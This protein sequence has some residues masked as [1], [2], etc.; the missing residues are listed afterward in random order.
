[1]KPPKPKICEHCKSKF[2]P[3][4][5]FQTWCSNECAYEIA[6]RKKEKQIKKEIRV[7]KEKIKTHSDHLK[8][9]Q[10]LV[11]KYVRLRDYG[12]PCI[13]CDAILGRVKYDAG[14]YF[15]VGGYPGLRFDEEN[16]HGQC[17]YCNQHLHSNS[18]EYEERLPARIGQGQFELLKSR[19]HQ[20]NKLTISEIEEMKKLYKE[21]LKQIQK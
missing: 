5:S 8:D 6:K 10:V 13:S 3:Y 14:H 9:L 1:M 4:R 15:S 17:V 20:S 7:M 21:K 11:N 2:I 19:K 12:K 18:H 16:I